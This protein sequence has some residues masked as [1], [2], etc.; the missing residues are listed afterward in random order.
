MFNNK[1]QGITLSFVARN[2]FTIKKHVPGIDPESNYSNGP[3]GIEQ[4][5]VPYTRTFGLNLNVKF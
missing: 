5:Q 2:V 4:A 3:Q 1:I